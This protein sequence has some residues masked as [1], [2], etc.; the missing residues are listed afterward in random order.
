MY[1]LDTGLNSISVNAMDC[2]GFSGNTSLLTRTQ[3]LFSGATVVSV[4][5][6]K[7]GPTSGD[8][9][10]YHWAGGTKVIVR[11]ETAT[12]VEVWNKQ[13]TTGEGNQKSYQISNAETYLYVILSGTS[14]KLVR[15]NTSDGSL[16][17]GTQL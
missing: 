15:I 7:I 13:Y 5:T 4:P 11:R 3:H 9:Y 17:Q 16:A 12:E 6:V 1:C 8:S 14:L 10:Y 2:P